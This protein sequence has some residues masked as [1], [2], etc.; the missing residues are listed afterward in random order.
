MS[1]SIN[2]K[3]DRTSKDD[4]YGKESSLEQFPPRPVL[5]PSSP[6]SITISAGLN[7]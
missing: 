3:N 7:D 4:T 2:V 1:A 6:H 5:G